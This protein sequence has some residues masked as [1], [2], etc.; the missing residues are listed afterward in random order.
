MTI[1]YKLL[2]T[3]YNM[4][5][6]PLWRARLVSLP[7][8]SVTRYE[9]VLMF[10]V[11]H[12]ITDAFTNMI[13]CRETLQVL[14]A[15]MTGH[16]YEPPF[17]AFTPFICDNLTTKSD[18]LPALKF[19]LYK[20]YSPT[21]GNFNKNVYFHGTIPQP[22]VKTAST[23]ILYQDLSVGATRNL[24][25][26][27]KEEG[28]TVHSCIM[29]AATLAVFH[30]A[31]QLSDVDLEPATIKVMNCVNM[32]R[33]YPREYRE[34]TG[35]HISVEEQELVINGSDGSSK[36]SFWSL[37]RQSHASLQKSL[38]VDKNPIR[39][40][41]GLLPCSL[42]I[43]GNYS[44][45]RNGRRNLNDSHM[46]TTN[47]GDLRDLLPARYDHGPVEIT[48][49]LRCVSDELTGHPYTLIFHTFRDRLNVTLEYYSNKI[50]HD[51][52]ARYFSILTNFISDLAEHGSVNLPNDR[53]VKTKK[54]KLI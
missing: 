53:K 24:L 45:T 33:Y 23:S 54:N 30:S 27:C 36:I 34:A 40:L 11:H 14:N 7:Q 50:A 25:K 2:G 16:V 28:V 52:A 31:Q 15:A 43:P 10:T 38:L 39:N 19:A 5:Q 46:I 26:Y 9:A 22:K 13:I 1:Y 41:L 8:T 47:M 17:R 51:D 37:A 48:K 49:L 3:S 21:L 4:F 6:G 29:T 18:W 44:L 32:R 20:L 12:C 35:C 42:L